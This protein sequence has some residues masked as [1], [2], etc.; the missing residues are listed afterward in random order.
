MKKR[1][2][3][4]IL[5][6]GISLLAWAAIPD[7]PATTRWVCDYA[8]I[9]DATVA[10]QLNNEL[11]EFSDTSTNQIVVVTVEDLEDYDRADYAV[12]LFNKWGIGNK[13]KNNGVLVL[14]KPRN[15]YGKGQVY[16]CTGY[17]A[18]AE[19]T[20]A[21]CGKLIDT[22]MMAYLADGNYTSA[23][24]SVIPSL[25]EALT[26]EF[27]NLD[28]G[29]TSDDNGDYSDDDDSFW[30]YILGFFVLW[31]IVEYIKTHPS[32]KTL[33]KR[34]IK[35]AGTLEE[36]NQCIENA[37]ALG[38]SDRKIN[39]LIKDNQKFTEGRLL[40][41]GSPQIFE[42]IAIAALALGLTAELISQLREKMPKQSLRDLKK[43]KSRSDIDRLVQRA[44]EF[45][46]DEDSV[47]AAK[48]SALASIAAAELA[49]E[50]ARRRSSG[51]GGGSS[52]SSFGGGRSGGGGAG[53]SF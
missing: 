39:S 44:S 6:I 17:G 45:G 12:Q 3:L 28:W 48:K 26:S 37:K 34:S 21:K 16:I 7:K 1:T 11:Q 51:G 24:T 32:K 29:N 20:D 42:Q 13:E 50:R 23:I 47:M 40:E 19:L 8:N 5:F 15:E 38:I 41:A 18:E 49:A 25:K 53:R 52:H 2:L 4:S 43:C 14:L 22:Y 30:W 10:E 31:G 36:R 35:K 27:A 33:A 46:N 9:L